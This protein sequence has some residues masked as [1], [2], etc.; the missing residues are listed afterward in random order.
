[1]RDRDRYRRT[2]EVNWFIF[3][4]LQFMKL[5]IM[6]LSGQENCSRWRWRGRQDD[7]GIGI[8]I[9]VGVGIIPFA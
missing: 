6:K 5:F 8:G 7:I 2:F 3:K 9:G 4:V 1:M